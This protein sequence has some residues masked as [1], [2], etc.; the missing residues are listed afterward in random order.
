MATDPL[1]VLIADLDRPDKPTIR[2]AVDKLIERAANS[3]SVRHAL[4]RRLTEPDH[5]NYWPAAYILGHLPDPSA[6]TIGILLDTLNHSEPDIR[7][8]IDRKSVV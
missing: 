6:A 4:E 2:A 3:E 8:A 7:W 1:A 5:R